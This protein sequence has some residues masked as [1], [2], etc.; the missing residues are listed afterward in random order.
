[1]PFVSSSNSKVSGYGG[2]ATNS[3]NDLLYISIIS[4][5]DFMW[6]EPSVAI[7]EQNPTCMPLW[8][9]RTVPCE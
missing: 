3:M 5:T 2:K 1:M 7:Y 8:N 6:A 4:R 9:E